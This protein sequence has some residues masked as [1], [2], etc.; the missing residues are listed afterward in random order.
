VV[1]DLDTDPLRAPSIQSAVAARPDAF[2]RLYAEGG[3][4][5]Y[6]FDSTRASLP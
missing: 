6:A 3:F 4:T 2:R 1:G 5:V